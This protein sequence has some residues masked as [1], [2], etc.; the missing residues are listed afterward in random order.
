MVRQ[1]AYGGVALGSYR[2][3]DTFARFDFLDIREGLLVKGAALFTGWIVR[4]QNH[5]R[6]L[7]VDKGIWTVL[8]LTCGITFGV[9]IG[10]LLQLQRA[11]ERDWEMNPAAEEEKISGAEHLA[12]QLFIHRIMRQHCLQLAGNM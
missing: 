1:L 5:Y 9:D 8:H 12:G 4:G 11:F 10:D 7:F 2:D 6:E 3:H